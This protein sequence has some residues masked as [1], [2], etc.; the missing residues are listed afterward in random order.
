VD[1]GAAVRGAA[2]GCY[3]DAD[4]DVLLPSCSI[5]V[6]ADLLLMADAPRGEVFFA[7]M[8]AT[9]DEMR[10]KAEIQRDVVNSVSYRWSADTVEARAASRFAT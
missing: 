3:A 6:V 5:P 8:A 9:L 4:A 1:S 2:Q 7:V 10:E